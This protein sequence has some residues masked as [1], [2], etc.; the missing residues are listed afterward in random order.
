MSRSRGDREENGPLFDTGAFAPPVAGYLLTVSI[1]F[2]KIKELLGAIFAPVGFRLV[3]FASPCVGARSTRPV[4]RRSNYVK[5]SRDGE[6][7]LDRS[8]RC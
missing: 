5:I 4:A 8:V 6:L 1:L 7:R 2:L 3:L